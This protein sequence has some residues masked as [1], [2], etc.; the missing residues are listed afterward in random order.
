LQKKIAIV[1][2]KGQPIPPGEQI[3]ASDL[4]ENPGQP[5]ISQELEQ[6]RI[7]AVEKLGI[8]AFNISSE[9]PTFVWFHDM[10]QSA[11]QEI[12]GQLL[13]MLNSHTSPQGDATSNAYAVLKWLK[14]PET[15]ETIAQL[16]PPP[17]S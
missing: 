5:N 15:K 1:T 4:P 14:H 3:K 7:N 17:A 2:A 13:D 6:K 8:Y 10:L 16:L 11:P 9:A 12:A